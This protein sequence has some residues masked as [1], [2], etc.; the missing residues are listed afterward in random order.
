MKHTYTGLFRFTP[1]RGDSVDGF[2]SHD[3]DVIKQSIIT[4]IK[5]PK[6]SRIYDPNLGTNLHRLIHEQNIKRIRNIAI[7]EIEDVISKYEPRVEVISIDA[8]VSGEV[9]QEVII[10]VAVKYLEFNTTEILEI[11][12]ESDTQW[13]NN[14]DKGYDPM[15]ELFKNYNL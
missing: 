3:K 5:T 12:F 14:T 2:V 11:K 9:K 7:N 8:V 4:L 10:L 6:G 15:E 1:K 13:I